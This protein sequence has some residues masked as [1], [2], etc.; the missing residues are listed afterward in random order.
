VTRTSTWRI[1]DCAPYSQL[2][3]R[4]EL[5]TTLKTVPSDGNRSSIEG[6]QSASAA[7]AA[8]PY[9]SLELDG[10]AWL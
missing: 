4:L 9:R 1:L 2:H 7:R 8:Q 6:N 5:K 10:V 3:K